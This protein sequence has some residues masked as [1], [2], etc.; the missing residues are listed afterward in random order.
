MT[1]WAA[2]DQ[3]MQI[4]SHSLTS[5]HLPFYDEMIGNAQNREKGRKKG[6]HYELIMCGMI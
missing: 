6:R 1:R 4:K 3:L 2:L 5:N